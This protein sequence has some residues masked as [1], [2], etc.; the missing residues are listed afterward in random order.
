MPTK[1]TLD[2]GETFKE[3][4]KSQKW[5]LHGVYPNKFPAGD[6]H[7]WVFYIRAT[8]LGTYTDSGSARHEYWLS[9]C[10][11][12]GS[13][14]RESMVRLSNLAIAMGLTT[15]AAF[16]GMSVEQYLDALVA[17]FKYPSQPKTT[18]KAG[19]NFWFKHKD[20]GYLD[21]K[22][23]FSYMDNFD[24]KEPLEEPVEISG[25]ELPF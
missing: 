6:K 18:F 9:D 1:E 13:I 5:E 11:E 12:K 10:S 7:K 3:R 21:S 25:E 15:K 19:L 8:G 20:N 17:I 2:V 22:I 16:E 4:I 14:K 23:D 24:C